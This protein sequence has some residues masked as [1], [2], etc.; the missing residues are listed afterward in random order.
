[1]S[2]HSSHRLGIITFRDQ[3]LFNFDAYTAVP[4][5]VQSA[6][7]VK[8]FTAAYGDY[9]VGALILGAD[10]TVMVSS[11]TAKNSLKEREEISIRVKALCIED[12]E[13]KDWHQEHA[14]MTR[15]MKLSG[16]DSFDGLLASGQDEVNASFDPARLRDMIQ[17]G[18]TIDKRVD[19]KFKSFNLVDKMVVDASMCD[20]L[21]ESGLVVGLLLKPF[22]KCAD[23]AIARNRRIR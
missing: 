9:Y 6:K 8:S 1:M 13:S 20:R 16:F 23:Y 3:P 2:L 14:D 22:A 15:G 4:T 5:R 19:E 11:S 17:K 21:C 10:N 7:D 12:E 18:R